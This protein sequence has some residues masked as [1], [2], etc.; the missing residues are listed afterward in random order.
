MQTIV[1][2]IIEVDHGDKWIDDEIGP[3]VCFAEAD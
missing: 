2:F 3:E 1:D